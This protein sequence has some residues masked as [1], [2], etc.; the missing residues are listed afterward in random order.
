MCT[1]FCDKCQKGTKNKN[2]TKTK[3]NKNEIKTFLFASHFFGKLSIKNSEEH[4][5]SQTYRTQKYQ[6]Q[7][8]LEYLTFE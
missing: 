8:G 1:A 6:I 3:Q 2:K 4:T 5:Q 7:W